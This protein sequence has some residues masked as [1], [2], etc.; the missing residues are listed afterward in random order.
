MSR[1]LYVLP[2]LLTVACGPKVTVKEKA[3]VYHLLTKVG[4]LFAGGGG[5]GVA[6]DTYTSK[7][8]ITCPRGG[9]MS[10]EY[11]ATYA[12]GST[13]STMSGA[14]S[15]NACAMTN[16]TKISG[17]GKINYAM[18]TASFTSGTYKMTLT[19]DGTYSLEDTAAGT[20]DDLVMHPLTIDMSYASA[21]GKM[22]LTYVLNGTVDAN[23]VS[24]VFT[25]DT[26]TST[27]EVTT[28]VTP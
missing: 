24:Y 22:T 7:V 27:I 28:T 11:S 15:Y 1:S 12:A 5:F 9:S 10:M 18:D 6:R 26:Y 3:D 20:K 8:S 14:Y 25:N 13:S 2:L 21:N 4:T 19:Y 17:S 16:S 23:G